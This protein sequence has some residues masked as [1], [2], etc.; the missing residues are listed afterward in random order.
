MSVA[1]AVLYRKKARKVVF[2]LQKLEKELCN[3]NKEKIKEIIQMIRK[4]FDVKS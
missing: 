2:E 1:I 4:E 3:R